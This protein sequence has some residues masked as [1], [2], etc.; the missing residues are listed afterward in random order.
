MMTSSTSNTSEYCPT[1]ETK[2]R[3]IQ[4]LMQVNLVRGAWKY[5]IPLIVVDVQTVSITRIENTRFCRMQMG[6]EGSRNQM[7]ICRI[8]SV[9]FLSMKLHLVL[10][11][12]QNSYRTS[13][14]KM[15]FVRLQVQSFVPNGLFPTFLQELNPS[16][17]LQ[18]PTSQ[19]EALA[20]H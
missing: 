6:K 7:I 4:H 19:K 20:F 15:N 9:R 2:T 16:K 13:Q 5:E 18:F 8:R 14:S 11:I 1:L 17:F 3:K 10:E 12:L